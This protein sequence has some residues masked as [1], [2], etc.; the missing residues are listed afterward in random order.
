MSQSTGEM[1]PTEIAEAYFT[2]VSQQM[3]IARNKPE[4]SHVVYGLH[5]TAEGL[6][7]MAVGLRATYLL[8]KEVKEMLRRQSAQNSARP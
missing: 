8:L 2:A 7:A 1:K 4:L 6:Q 3:A 5:K